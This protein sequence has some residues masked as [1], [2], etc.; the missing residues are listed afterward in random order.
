[1]IVGPPSMEMVC[2]K[3]EDTETPAELVIIDV[4]SPPPSQQQQQQP[5]PQKQQQQQQ[6]QS[7]VKPVSSFGP[8][9]K[10]VI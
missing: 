9:W 7:K 6:Q 8:T 4:E 1:M 2:V 10:S 3:E 5:P